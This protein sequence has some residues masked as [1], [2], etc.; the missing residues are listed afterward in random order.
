MDGTV[1]IEDGP[2]GS[3]NLMLYASGRRFRISG[4]AVA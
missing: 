3:Q 2:A 4:G 1:L